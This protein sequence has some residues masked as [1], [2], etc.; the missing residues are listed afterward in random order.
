M[1]EIDVVR[2]ISGKFRQAGILLVFNPLQTAREHVTINGGAIPLH[3]AHGAG[4][5][6][7]CVAKEEIS[8]WREHFRTI[9]IAI[10]SKVDWP[11]GAH[12]IYFRDP[13]GNSLELATPD[14]W[15]DIKS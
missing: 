14:M 8:A 6:A 5:T 9:G 3:G 13:A 1:N 12:S 15:A 10:E 2:G 11:N 7:F 4:H